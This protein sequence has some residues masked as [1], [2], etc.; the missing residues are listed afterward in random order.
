[1]ISND[2]LRMMSRYNRWQN[3]EIYAAAA[4]LTEEERRADRGAFWQSIH[5]TLSHLYW[6]DRLWL[7]RFDVTE[8]PN[9]PQKSS[10]TFVAAWPTLQRERRALDDLMVAW[11]DRFEEGPVDGVLKWFSGSLGREVEAPLSVVLPHFFNHQTHHRGQ[12]HAMVTAAGGRTGDTDLF[13]MPPD[14]W[15]DR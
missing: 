2:F 6:A 1:M 15:P 7:S 11:T 10:A 8:A 14:M 13:L 5:G 12:A 9:V 4:V 3:A